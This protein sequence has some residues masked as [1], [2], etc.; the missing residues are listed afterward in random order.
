MIYRY[1][2]PLKVRGIHLIFQ[3]DITIKTAIE[4]GIEDMRKNPWL[5]QDVLS[6]CV[7]NPYLKQK[8]GQK[9]VDAFT[10]WFTNNNIQVVLRP[11]NDK[12][13]MPLVAITPG[14][15]TEKDDMKHLDDQ[16]TE[17]TMLLPQQ[18]N[19]PI[20]YIVKPFTPLGYDPRTG[21]VSVDP[22]IKGMD[23]IVAG[24]ILVDPSNGQ[25]FVIQDVTAA[26][27]EI[28]TGVDLDATQLA[29]VPQFQ[30]YT[31]RIKHA[32]FRESAEIACYSHGDPQVCLWLHSIVLYSILRYRESLLEANGFAESNVSNGPL[33]EDPNY[34][35]PDGEQA[36][37]RSVQ[38]T[39]QTEHTWIAAPRR[40]IESI[41]LKEK[42]G[43]GFI[44][45]IRI[46]SNADSA[47]FIDKSQQAWYTDLDEGS[48]PDDE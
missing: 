13:S 7:T 8:Y 10:E 5:L 4:L 27:I 37:V 30:Y 9:Q 11:R 40:T 41:G 45:G 46:L 6:D 31:A 28:L 22:T 2:S 21:I 32:F 3:L 12:D 23:S 34:S 36:F 16:S 33:Q 19:K 38:L 20:A 42:V 29:V 24:Q 14:P 1:K 39:G 17:S 25:G 26:G 48:L 44:G 18:I 15:A 35:G 43:D 47:S